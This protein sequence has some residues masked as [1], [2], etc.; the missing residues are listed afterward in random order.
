[1]ETNMINEKAVIVLEEL[2]KEIRTIKKNILETKAIKLKGKIKAK[3][4]EEEI[5]K[6]KKEVFR[7][8]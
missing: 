6:A 1:M 4:N 3:V 2:E 5:D 7:A 8:Y